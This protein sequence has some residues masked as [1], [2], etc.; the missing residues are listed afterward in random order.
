M[1]GKADGIIKIFRYTCALG[2][3][4]VGFMTIVG[5]GGGWDIPE[6]IYEGMYTSIA[7]D[8][9]NGDGILDIAVTYTIIDNPPPH[10]SYI[11]V[12]LQDP[13][14]PGSFQSPNHYAIGN[15]AWSIAIGDLN[16]DGLPDLAAANNSSNSISI[17]FQDSAVPGT[18]LATK[19]F[20]TGIYPLHVAIGD[21]NGDGL[22]DLLIADKNTSIL[23]Q[24]P[25]TPGTFLPATS[26][27]LRSNC[28][29]IG[30]LNTDNLPD[31]AITGAKDGAVAVLLQDATNPGEFLP[32]TYF[33]TGPQPSFVSIGLIDGDLLP[34]LAVVNYGSPDGSVNGSVSVLLQNPSTPGSFLTP[35]NYVTGRRSDEVA[36][37]DLNGDNLTDLAVVNSRSQSSD[38][39]DPGIVSVLLQN[40]SAAGTFHGPTDYEIFFQPLSIATGDLN[41]DSLSDIAVADD[42]ANVLFQNPN[43][44]GIFFPPIRAGG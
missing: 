37:E 34:D 30:D 7:L 20:P 10:Q 9:L 36:I 27:G 22:G 21:I 6:S 19:N 14:E 38:F 5:T 16:D 35:N 24:D 26:L 2:V 29:A 8:D 42:G 23:L 15:D 28:V 40:P 13:L 44:P 31:L 1:M 3:L 25:S 4:F 33:D 39:F 11:S 43:S 17:L 18:F 12:I 32:A 41:G